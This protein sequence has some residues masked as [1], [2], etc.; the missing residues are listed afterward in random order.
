[1]ATVRTGG[2]GSWGVKDFYKSNEPVYFQLNDPTTGDP[3]SGGVLGT[4]V[5]VKVFNP[6]GSTHDKDANSP[7][8][9]TLTSLGNGMYLMALWGEGA[10]ANSHDFDLKLEG[11][12][13]VKIYP[14]AAEFATQVFTYDVVKQLDAKL[15][16]TY[17]PGT[18]GSDQITGCLSI[19]RWKTKQHM[20]S[21]LT[22]T[23]R[24]A[25]EGTQT[26]QNMTITITDKDSTSN[27]VSLSGTDLVENTFDGNVY[28]TKAINGITGARVLTVRLKFQ[29]IND[30]AQTSSVFDFEIPARFAA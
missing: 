17:L 19:F 22:A 8:A 2:I 20:F 1:M 7:P 14:T 29:Y 26:L 23:N 4:N 13:G 27:I 30:T 18:A 28:F 10:S 9:F 6:A 3:Y 5:K 24:D 25:S 15:A 12:Y 21:P 16:V 11:T